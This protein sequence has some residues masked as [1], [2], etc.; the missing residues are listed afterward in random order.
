LVYEHNAG[1]ETSYNKF[2]DGNDEDGYVEMVFAEDENIVKLCLALAFASVQTPERVEI[3]TS[4]HSTFMVAADFE[5]ILGQY[6]AGVRNDILTS[7]DAL[8]NDEDT[9]KP[10]GQWVKVKFFF[11][12]GSFQKL[13]DAIIKFFPLS[14][15]YNT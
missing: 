7:S 11:A 9:T 8:T 6:E 15:G 12:T 5:D 10:H 1:D 2:Y 3:E 4:L 13:T 14:R